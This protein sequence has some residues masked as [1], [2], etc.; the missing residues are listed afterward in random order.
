LEALLHAQG[1]RRRQLVLFG[2]RPV[3]PKR[4]FVA[5]CKFIDFTE[6]SIAQYSRRLGAQRRF[7]GICLNFSIAA[8][9][10]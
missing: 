10:G 5:A 2:E 6:K 3:R 9:S 1:I 4:G 8:G 7:G